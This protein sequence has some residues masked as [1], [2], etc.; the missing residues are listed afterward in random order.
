MYMV[1]GEDSISGQ[2]AFERSLSEIKIIR[3]VF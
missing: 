1:T 3:K 2:M